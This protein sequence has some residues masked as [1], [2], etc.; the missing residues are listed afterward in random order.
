MSTTGDSGVPQGAVLGLLLFFLQI[1][2]PYTRHNSVLWIC[3]VR[4]FAD[5]YLVYRPIRSDTDQ[6]LL[7]QDLC[8][9]E[10]GRAIHETCASMLLNVTLCLYRALVIPQSH[11]LTVQSRVVRGWY[12]QIFWH[13][14]VLRD[15]L[16]PHFNSVVSKT[17][18]TLGF[19]RRNLRKCPSKSKETAYSSLVP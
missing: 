5:G 15:Q 4:L 17:N 19:L 11:V 18:S 6:V 1:R 14:P 10:L 16:V 8:A 2:A 3:K 13:Q 9:L 7:Q 12:S